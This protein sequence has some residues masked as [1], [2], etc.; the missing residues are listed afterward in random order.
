MTPN[1]F[2]FWQKAYLAALARL[3]TNQSGTML[4]DT[5]YAATVAHDSLSYYRSAKAT[6]V[7]TT[8]AT[9]D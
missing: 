3:S 6:V 7:K 9:A 8:Y 5:D 1:E 2:E 4:E